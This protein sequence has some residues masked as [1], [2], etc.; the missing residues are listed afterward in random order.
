MTATMPEQDRENKQAVSMRFSLEAL[1][2]LTE[3]S[4]DLGISRTAVVELAI[5]EK[6]KRDG[7]RDGSDR[8]GRE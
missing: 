1:R 7:Y 2:L 5:R 6:A 4:R 3:M 8:D